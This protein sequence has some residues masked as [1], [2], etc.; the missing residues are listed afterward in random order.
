MYEEESGQ[1]AGLSSALRRGGRTKCFD[2]GHV[3]A[4]TSCLNE[5]CPNVVHFACALRRRRGASHQ[6]IFTADRSFLCSP[7]CHSAVRR[8][9]FCELIKELRLRKRDNAGLDDNVVDDDDM[10]D[11]EG[12]IEAI[13]SDQRDVVSLIAAGIIT[14]DEAQELARKID[15]DLDVG[16]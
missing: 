14:S 1:L 2:C 12:E 9:R 4:T 15:S 6:P 16:L 10:M 13:N 3:G 8:Q 7:A 11:E 5:A